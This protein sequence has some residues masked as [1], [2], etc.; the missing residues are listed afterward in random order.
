MK[1]LTLLSLHLIVVLMNPTPIQADTPSSSQSC[2]LMEQGNKSYST[3][4][5]YLCSLATF[6][7]IS[8]NALLNSP[9]P[10]YEQFI[11]TYHDDVPDET[12]YSIEPIT[13]RIWFTSETHPV[14]A[15]ADRLRF[16]NTSLQFYAEKPFQH[17][18]W[19]NGAHLIP[20]TI[21][22]INSFNVPVV[23][24]DIS[25]VV[26]QFVTKER[27]QKFLKGGR[28]VFASDLARQEIIFIYGGLYADIG[29]EQLRDIGTYFKKYDW[30]QI[31]FPGGI[32]I[33]TFAL[34]A[35]KN[36]PLIKGALHFIKN[37]P[38][39]LIQL[40]T[41]PKSLVLVGLHSW[42]A[43]KLIWALENEPLSKIGFVYKNIDF[44]YHGLASW[45]ITLDSFTANHY[46]AD[47][48]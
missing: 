12:P 35:K 24:H 11:K 46:L 14:E 28:F 45:L 1:H 4:K 26:D 42:Y 18:F 6:Y 40:P 44:K 21:A 31:I 5:N 19:C 47:E 2:F 30:I 39:T 7:N 32:E 20:Q 16:Y 9:R 29:L 3:A 15:P 37:I 34:G 43:W 8:C 10:Y 33:N 38:Q 13:H 17:H 48:I 36:S 23:I 22:A 41:L 25:E 27:F